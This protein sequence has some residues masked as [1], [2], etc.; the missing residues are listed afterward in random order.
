MHRNRFTADKK[1]PPPL[2]AIK[3]YK[4]KPKVRAPFD[5]F[6]TFWAKRRDCDSEDLWDTDMCYAALVAL[7]WKRAIE[8]GRIGRL[9][10]RVEK[11]SG[12]DDDDDDGNELDDC[13]IVFR[14]NARLVY[15]IYDEYSVL[16]ASDLDDV[17]SIG[18]SGFMQ[19]VEDL[20]L[21]LKHS[22]TCRLSD[23]DVRLGL[24]APL[25]DAAN[26]RPCFAPAVP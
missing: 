20:Q 24:A 12:G 18:L 3:P 10:T 7:D 9:V 26:S 4:K 1:A 22:K 8:D 6:S 19:M 13:E 23:L 25:P 17:Y 2:K 16:G 15:S 11:K 21:D 14:E 5:L